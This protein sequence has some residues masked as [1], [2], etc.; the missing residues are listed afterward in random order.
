MDCYFWS[1]KLAKKM[2]FWG[3]RNLIGSLG[4][5][6]LSSGLWA[7]DYTSTVISLEDGLSQSTIFTMAQDQLGF[8]WFGTEDGLNRYDG[9]GFKVF[10]NE[11]FDST[12]LPHN[13]VSSLLVDREDRLWVGMAMRGLA[14]F[15]PIKEQF[16]SFTHNEEDPYSLSGNNVNCVY[17]DLGGQVWVGTAQGLNLLQEQSGEISFLRSQ[18]APGIARE[19]GYRHI[20][21]LLEDPQG[22]L[23]VGTQAGLARYNRLSGQLEAVSLQPIQKVRDSRQLPARPITALA[24]GRE[25]ALWLGTPRGLWRWDPGSSQPPQAF[26]TGESASGSHISCLV[27]SRDGGLYLGT[28]GRGMFHLVPGQQEAEWVHFSSQNK[29][30]RKLSN[31][32]IRSLHIDQ[33]NPHILWVGHTTGGIEKLVPDQAVFHSD[34]LL[35]PALNRLQSQYVSGLAK[36]STGTLW[37]ATAN[38]L[39]RKPPDGSYDLFQST[40]QAAGSLW[41]NG[42]SALFLDSQER[43]WIGS[44]RGLNRL[45]ALQAKNPVFNKLRLNPECNGREAGAFFEDEKGFIYLALGQGLNVFHP[46]KQQFWSCSI[47]PDP[48]MSQ[49]VGYRVFSIRKDRKQRLWIGSSIGLILYEE[50]VDPWR[51]LPGAQPHIFYHQPHDPQSL[52][53]HT[54]LCVQEDQQGTIWL[55]TFNGLIKVEEKAGEMHFRP[56]T[57]K[58]GLA[59]NVVYGILEDPE[60]GV[61]WMSTNNG[62][63]R[64]E[65]QSG[66]FENF[67]SRDGLQSN[68]FNG[69]AYHRAEDGEMMF[70]GI[71][72][73]TRFFPT[74]IQTDSMPP[75]VWLTSLTTAKGRAFNLLQS[76]RSSLE[77]SYAENSFSLRFLALN[78][79]QPRDNQYAYRLEGR[80][81]EWIPSQGT[82]QVNFSELA[83][84]TYTFRVKGSNSAGV[85]NETGD[86]LRIVIRPPFWQ[87]LWFYFL[88]AG[89]LGLAFGLFHQYRVRAKVRRVMEMER[90]RKNAAADFHDELGHKLTVI[91]LFGEIV[92]K[93]SK[94]Q[95]ELLPHLNKIIENANSLYYSMK[96]LLWVLDP[97]KD[98]VYDLVILLKDFGDELFDKTGVAFRTEGIVEAMREQNLPMDHKRH[99]VLIFKEV[100]NNALKHAQ[101]QN[102]R[103][104]AHFV[105]GKLRLLFEDDGKGFDLDQQSGGNGLTNIRNR[106]QKIGARL[107]LTSGEQGT[108]VS[109]ELG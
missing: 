39:L 93:K 32:L 63:S 102:A 7:Q 76:D 37:V 12:S 52:R 35:H 95:E 25:G 50:V 101:C 66:Q 23:W 108:R 24:L 27:P 14:L 98:S 68:E 81:Q 29:T 40:S 51:D 99:I 94:G 46:Q 89:L 64:F 10:K 19:V 86:S 85:W 87:T 47:I 92:K 73:F 6:L 16:Q 100:M 72:G 54:I 103:L 82:R 109:L 20:R 48:E 61:L 78:Y 15:D 42:L 83:P 74:Q 88:I 2:V 13:Q 38:G 49:Q 44:S 70:G 105:H 5:L 91:S 36:D 75:Q 21:C 107:Q 53:N 45:D 1:A 11:P 60:T 97:N 30:E 65:P 41:A 106:A 71:Q 69:R 67:D 80:D 77:L 104:Q 79:V 31:D 96:D 59:N 55:G 9:Y 43:L 58:D 22:T 57:E 28:I 26:L 18:L 3:M 84:G 33:L 56:Y 62:L 4:L 90:V 17:E 34:D 8:M